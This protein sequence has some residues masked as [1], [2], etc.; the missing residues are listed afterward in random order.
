L[1]CSAPSRAH[2]W[3]STTRRSGRISSKA[4]FGAAERLRIY[5]NTCRSALVETLRMSYPA[6]ERLVGGD[7]FDMATERYTDAHPARSGYLNDYGGAFAAFLARLDAA[8]DLRYLPDVARFEWA[9]SIAANASDAPVIEATALLAVDIDDRVDLRFEAHPSVQ[10][11][12]LEHPAD[13]IADAVLA[14]DE[15]AMREIDL[16]GGPLRLVVHRGP[17]GL[18]TERLQ[19]SA[20]T[21]VSRLCAGERF[22]AL[23]EPD[24]EQAAALLG[25]QFVKGR[26]SAFRIAP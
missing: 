19:G 15:A 18:E 4:R 24:P 20:Y 9:L 21:F 23:L 13:E 12:K 25:E 16:A 1:S 11:L 26:L 14:G 10:L 22:G 5:R 8:R 3:T 6:V 7:F 2:C 17:H